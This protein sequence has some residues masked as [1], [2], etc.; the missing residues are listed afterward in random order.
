MRS[1]IEE[2]NTF[3]EIRQKKDVVYFIHHKAMAIKDVIKLNGKFVTI[4]NVLV[5]DV[6]R[7][8]TKEGNDVRIISMIN[9]TGVEE[10]IN[11]DTMKIDKI[12]LCS[13]LGLTSINYFD[14]THFE[15][16]MK[17]IGEDYVR[18]F[19]YIV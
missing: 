12:K 4:K 10:I 18:V 13:A 9:E 19:L 6:P 14:I 8:F 5:V 1:R 16:L 15:R 17:R 3:R 2:I 7:D 11:R